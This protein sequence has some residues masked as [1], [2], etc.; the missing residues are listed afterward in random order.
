MDFSLSAD[1]GTFGSNFSVARGPVVLSLAALDFAV[2]NFP[3]ALSG[4]ASVLCAARLSIGE[5]GFGLVSITPFGLA[6]GFGLGLAR[7]VPVA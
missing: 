4:F 7:A 3:A 5:P 1:R 2:L 6:W